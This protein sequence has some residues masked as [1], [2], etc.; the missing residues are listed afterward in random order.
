M[1][2]RLFDT[3]FL[4]SSLNKIESDATEN[5]S[6]IQA[7]IKYSGIPS[8][9]LYTLAID[10]F[11]CETVNFFQTPLKTFV[12]KQEDEFGAVKKDQYY[13]LD[14]SLGKTK[15]SPYSSEASRLTNEDQKFGTYSRNSSF[16]FPLIASGSSKDTLGFRSGNPA[17]VYYL[18]DP[19]IRNITYAAHVPPSQNGQGLARI[20]FKAPYSGRVSLEDIFSNSAVE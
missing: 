11:L 15:G 6:N 4:S 14:V 13:S 8:S 10:N 3:G 20:I 19:G 7:S 16:G 9:P 1:H 17:S 18:P 2:G 12:S 5:S